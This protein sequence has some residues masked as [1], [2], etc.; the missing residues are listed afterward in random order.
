MTNP[1]L[2]RQFEIV[3]EDMHRLYGSLHTADHIDAL[4]DA[5]IAER[6]AGATVDT[7][8]P[9]IVERIVSEKLEQQAADAGVADPKPREEILF[10]CQR[11]SGRSQLATA[12]TSWLVGDRIFVRTV[13][14]EPVGGINETVLKV[15]AE[16]GIPA[17]HLHQTEIVARTVH[18]ADVVVLLGVDERPDIPGDR[19]V[20]WDIAD[21][22]NASIEEVRAIADDVERHVRALL[23]D[24][25]FDEALS[26]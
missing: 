23:A 1:L 24:M 17:D 18:R 25:G 15:L 19:Y 9:V 26:A 11:N 22:E 5:T 12:I 7:F 8:L 6:T 13:G 10:V 4:M 14:L 20:E 3:R 16:R 2:N 21:P